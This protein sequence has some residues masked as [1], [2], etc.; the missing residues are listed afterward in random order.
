MPRVPCTP[1]GSMQE[2][3]RMPAAPCQRTGRDSSPYRRVRRIP[4]STAQRSEH[5]AA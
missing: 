2:M 1:A 5:R 3:I 4:A